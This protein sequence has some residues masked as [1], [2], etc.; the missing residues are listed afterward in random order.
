MSSQPVATSLA[1]EVAAEAVGGVTLRLH[2]DVERVT[3]EIAYWLGARY[4][5]AAS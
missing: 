2:E 3:A 5:I 4:G 1:I